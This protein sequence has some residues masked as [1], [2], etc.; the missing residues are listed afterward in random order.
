MGI[1]FYLFPENAFYKAFLGLA[2]YGKLWIKSAAEFDINVTSEENPKIGI[3]S[4]GHFCVLLLQ[5]CDILR[6]RG[7]WNWSTQQGTEG[8]LNSWCKMRKWARV[9]HNLKNQKMSFNFSCSWESL[10]SKENQSWYNIPQDVRAGTKSELKEHMELQQM[11]PK[12][13]TTINSRSLTCWV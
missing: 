1:W 4:V 2:C 13:T 3:S 12:C 5:A 7:K 6:P 10:I 8:I 11:V 9:A